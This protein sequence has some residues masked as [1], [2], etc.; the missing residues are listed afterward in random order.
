VPPYQEVQASKESALIALTGIFSAS[1]IA[2]N[3]LGSRLV[4]IGP[5][6]VS[7]GIFVFPFTFLTADIVTELYGKETAMRVV[8]TGILLQVYVVLFVLL[9]FAFPTS[10]HRD[11]GA[12]Y[13][14]MFGLT[15]RM[16]LA[17]IVAYSI[18]QW[19]DVRIFSSLRKK[20]G[21]WL[22]LRANL[23]AWSSQFLDTLIFSSIFLGGVLPFHDWVRS[24]L[25]A[26]VTKIT[27]ATF[28]SPFVRIGVKFFAGSR[29]KGV[30]A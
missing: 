14:A 27:V 29:P 21:N 25:F 11:T 4:M 20:T 30:P 23:A 28:D 12:A 16:V 22:I 5:I 15:P 13:R 7:M 17:S 3:L 18:S 1:L 6:S 19:A 8:R 24:M 9:G 2:A 26:Y 10:P